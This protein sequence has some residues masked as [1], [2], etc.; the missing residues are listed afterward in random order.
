M[1][2]TQRYFCVHTH[3]NKYARVA[4]HIKVGSTILQCVNVT[5]TKI[6][7]LTVPCTQNQHFYSDGNVHS[8]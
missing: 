8:M 7:L 1:L 6:L 4:V 5:C 2:R 3:K